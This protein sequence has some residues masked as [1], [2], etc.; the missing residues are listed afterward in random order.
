[1]AGLLDGLGKLGLKNLEGMDLYE[2]PK[3]E[4]AK[5]EKKKE[6]GK[7]VKVVQE[8]DFLFDKTHECPVCGGK[9]KARTLKSGKAKLVRT[10]LDLRAVYQHIEP[11]KYDVITCPYCGYAALGRY[12]DTLTPSQIKVIKENIC[13]SFQPTVY[14]Q[15]TYTYEE[16][17]ERYKLSLANTIVK[18]GKASEKAYICLKAGWLL[19]GYGESL[20]KADLRYEEILSDCKKQ[21]R[22][23][24]KNSLEG[25]IAARQS[26][27][28]P[29]CGMDET[30]VD[31]LIAVL[32][33]EFEQYEISSHI[34]SNILISPSAGSR[35]K[36]RAREVKEILL[37]KMKEQK[38]G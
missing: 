24:M 27:G 5:L 9:I 38:K 31:Y 33:M 21:E 28:Y 22:E 29:M 6:V 35:M 12:F 16:A 20:D 34:I 4:E 26:E 13:K 17:V 14:S 3:E 23:F 10:D 25:F 8:K 11:L 37:A 30:T 19:R 2:T 7:P 36:D 32:A 1:M 18:R 15:E